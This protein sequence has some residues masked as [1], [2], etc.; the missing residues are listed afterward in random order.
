MH[1]T[2]FHWNL[3]ALASELH[4]PQPD[5]LMYFQ[6]GRRASFIVERRLAYEYLKGRI[7]DSEGAA[8][9]VF[10]KDGNKWEVRSLTKGGMYFC[11]SY[12]KGSGRKFDEIG[13]L[14]KLDEI[15]GYLIAQITD[16]PR[17]PV[18]QIAKK[19]VLKWWQ[20]GE[21]GTTSDISLKKA[22]SLFANPMA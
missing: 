2:T 7:A 22:I 4:I 21:L 15:E 12:M 1:V 11:P 19:Q 9:D 5:T 3:E 17:V 10:D 6:D 13:F 16:F 14:E 20:S 18:Y 8:F